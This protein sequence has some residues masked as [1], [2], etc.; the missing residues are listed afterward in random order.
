MDQHRRA[1]RQSIRNALS[2]IALTV[3]G[4]AAIVAHADDLIINVPV[5]LEAMEPEV[6]AVQVSCY[7]RCKR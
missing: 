5:E 3:A 7:V 2:A 1:H 4:C 6:H